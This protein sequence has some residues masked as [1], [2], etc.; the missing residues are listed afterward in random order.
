M[1]TYYGPLANVQ[2]LTNDGAPV[3]GSTGAGG[4]SP[5]ALLID[6]ANFAL[7]INAGS[8]AV[9]TW[10]QISHPSLS[11]AEVAVLDG[12]TPGTAAGGKAV[13]LD[14]NKDVTGIRRLSVDQLRLA[15]S[16]WEDVR[17][18]PSTFDFA[19]NSDP[20]KVNWQPGGSGATFK[21][22]EFDVGDEGFFLIQLPHARKPGTDLKLH[23]H[24]TPG[25]RG[26]EEINKTVAWKCD[27]SAA[28]IGS[29]FPASST[30]D[31]TDTVTG[32]DHL[33]EISPAA[34]IP[35]ATL[36]LSA[37]LMCRIYRHTG[38]TW[39]TNSTGNLPLLLEI[40]IHYEIDRLGSDNET[41]ND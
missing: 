34:T 20:T 39:A 24:W 8:Q 19:G 3:D 40:D 26:N 30:Y 28:S 12:V 33:H 36:G 10:M 15:D 5:G 2:V 17:I 38:D 22:W 9:P 37:M 18:E 4:A 41:S 6:V 31:M 32:T 1:T 27:I 16:V 23:V 25:T 29:A 14:A 11:A 21:V 13:V 7:Y 35:G